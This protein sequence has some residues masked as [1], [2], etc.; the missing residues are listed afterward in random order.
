MGCAS[1]PCLNGGNCVQLEVNAYKCECRPG[2]CMGEDLLGRRAPN[3]Y[4]NRFPPLDMQV[5]LES[6]ANLILTTNA[7]VIR[8]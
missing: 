7:P 6:T 3:V 8:A 2:T 5:F 4:T 1:N